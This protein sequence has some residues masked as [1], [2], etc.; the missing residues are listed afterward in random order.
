[1]TVINIEFCDVEWMRRRNPQAFALSDC[2]IGNAA[3]SA[4]NFS[5]GVDDIAR[6][7]SISTGREVLQK[8]FIVIIG[9]ETNFLTVGL[10][11]NR[12][13]HL[14]GKAARLSL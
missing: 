14:R 12:Q 8:S 11:G 9:H 4:E 13:I 10:V 2:V 3:V 1:M 7:Q 5:A 6:L